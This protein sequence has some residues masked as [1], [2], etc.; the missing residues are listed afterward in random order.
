MLHQCKICSYESIRLYDYKKHLSTDRHI[1]QVKSIEL[2]ELN[3]NREI[4]RKED[5]EF[6]V[7]QCRQIHKK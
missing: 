2:E 1:Q 4:E 5:R 6:L 3:K 7:K